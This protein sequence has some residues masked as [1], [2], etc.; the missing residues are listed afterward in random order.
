[1][2]TIL[3]P[4]KESSVPSREDPKESGLGTSELMIEMDKE[5][6]YFVLEGR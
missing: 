5:K 3:V 2:R 4:R 1:M 6:N